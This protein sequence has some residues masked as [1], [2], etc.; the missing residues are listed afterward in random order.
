MMLPTWNLGT[1]NCG[2]RISWVWNA[3]RSGCTDVHCTYEINTKNL[4][5]LNIIGHNIGT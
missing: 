3:F 1:K 2:N 4:I 5:R